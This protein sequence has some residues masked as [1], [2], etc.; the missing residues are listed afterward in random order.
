MAL[1][2]HGLLHCPNVRTTVVSKFVSLRG[3]FVEQM[4]DSR[5]RISTFPSPWAKQEG[6]SDNA[7]P[8]REEH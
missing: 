1:S 4:A 2:R 7:E 6:D 8:T 3:L 5:V